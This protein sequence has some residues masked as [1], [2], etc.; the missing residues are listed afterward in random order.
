[1]CEGDAT[2][3]AESLNARQD[4]NSRAAS[5]VL[6]R[7]SHPDSRLAI[8]HVGGISLTSQASP[9]LLEAYSYLFLFHER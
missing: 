4:A 3:P 8:P 6:P 2:K 5:A 9:V 7:S 1:M